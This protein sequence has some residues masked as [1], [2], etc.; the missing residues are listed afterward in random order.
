MELRNLVHELITLSV[1]H[2]YIITKAAMSAGIYIGQP[3]VLEYINVHDGCTQKE[4]AKALH[5]TA[6]SAAT[7]LKRMEKA[8]LISR[9]Q[10]EKDPR[11]NRISITPKGNASLEKF[12]KFCNATDE[13][14]FA[15]FTDEE[16]ETLHKFVCRLHNNLDS[17]NLTK[18]DI[19]KILHQ[20]KG[21][22]ED[23]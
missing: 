11:K 23:A 8:Q 15:G 22:T 20:E 5:I 21:E 19:C 6:P 13:K 10:D 2:R 14:M 16:M 9:T 7:S 12:I 17:E 3:N 18:E 4:L 1:V